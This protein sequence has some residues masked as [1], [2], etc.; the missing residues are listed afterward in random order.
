MH[1]SG[2]GSGARLHRTVLATSLFW[3]STTTTPSARDFCVVGFFLR[4]HEEALAFKV[5][6]SKLQ[7]KLE[8]ER[9]GSASSPR[10]AMCLLLLLRAD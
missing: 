6:L 1:G 7:T 2:P 3:P 8:A 9:N 10:S 5:H 4:N